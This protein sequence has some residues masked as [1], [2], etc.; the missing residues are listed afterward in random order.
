MEADLFLPLVGFDPRI[1]GNREEAPARRINHLRLC[2]RWA[3]NWG[4]TERNELLLI[5]LKFAWAIRATATLTRIED[6]LVAQVVESAERAITLSPK[7]RRSLCEL[8]QAHDAPKAA[9]TAFFNLAFS[10]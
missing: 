2:L 1:I 4:G 10:S 8:A 9:R 3:L 6:L 5:T 7:M